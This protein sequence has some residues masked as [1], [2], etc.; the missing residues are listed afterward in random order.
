MTLS[1]HTKACLILS[2]LPA[3]AGGCMA[4]MSRGWHSTLANV[5]LGKSAPLLGFLMV[6]SGPLSWYLPGPMHQPVLATLV[7]L[8]LVGMMSADSLVDTR[9][10]RGLTSG[11]FTLWWVCGLITVAAFALRRAA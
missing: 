7:S 2:I 1:R 4:A 5:P 6:L 9:M 3:F 8:G 10:A 11:G